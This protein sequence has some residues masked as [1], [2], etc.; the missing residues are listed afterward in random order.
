MPREKVDNSGKG[1]CMYY[2]YSISLM[3]FLL[4]KRNPEFAEQIFTKLELSE[5]QKKQLH[6]L[7]KNPQKLHFSAEQ[8][9]TIIEP[10]L[11]EATRR[12]AA[13]Q[14]KEE[15]LHKPKRS[16]L[17]TA[18][19]YGLLY[20]FR[21]EL[22]KNQ[23]PLAVLFEDQE[24]NLPDYT[25]AE[26]YKVFNI[27]KPDSELHQHMAKHYPTIIDRYFA[28][29]STQAEKIY[30][31]KLALLKRK[32]IE[33]YE[34][35][36]QFIKDLLQEGKLDFPQVINKFVSQWDLFLQ[37]TYEESD[38]TLSKI[39]LAKKPEL[40]YQFLHRL[41][42]KK[43]LS[44]IEAKAQ[45]PQEWEAY[46][47]KIVKEEIFTQEEIQAHILH[48]RLF[49]KEIIQNK[50][51]PFKEV[52][53]D[54]QTAWLALI[55]KLY[56]DQK[57]SIRKD[58]LSVTPF[59]HNAFLSNLVFETASQFFTANNNLNINKY[60]AHLDT[61]TVWGS[62]ETL[63]NLHDY[64][65]GRQEYPNGNDGVD[66]VY[67]NEM[68]LEIYHN[69]VP[70]SGSQLRR[71]DLLLN[72]LGR[73]HWVSLVEP[74]AAR[75]S[76]PTENHAKKTVVF[77]LEDKSKEEDSRLSI[78]LSQANKTTNQS[79]TDPISPTENRMAHLTFCGFN[80]Y[81]EQLE[82]KA[83]LLVKKSVKASEEAFNLCARLA[84][85]RKKF[86]AP[87]ATMSTK[88]FA[89][90][91]QGLIKEAPKCH[92]EKHRGIGIILNG[93]LNALI[94]L[95][96]IALRTGN[97]IYGR[98][99]L[100]DP[101]R[102]NTE[103]IKQVKAIDVSLEALKAIRARDDQKLIGLPPLAVAPESPRFK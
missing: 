62:E 18:I 35:Q 63:I 20:L 1:N 89:E 100:I 23:S 12:M 49:C 17:L 59:Y 38:K 82:E 78:H 87:N 55:E 51:L 64:L 96:N 54:H 61:N 30:Q 57:D 103:S 9:A 58:E 44:F 68:L 75:V 42:P 36:Q 85:E 52:I 76:S 53:K 3:Y 34:V 71:P 101:N 77:K 70:S 19:N 88:E 84:E 66:I 81:L 14:V 31:E 6:A 8:I 93:I 5:L 48:Q 22:E 13:L 15:L 86:I 32:I 47:A 4:N 39:D 46:V 50:T 83:A 56:Q 79:T 41:L 2:A 11:G 90:R 69:G 43:E 65:Q 40:R 21:L 45:Y 16:S 25:E 24:F 74:S 67:D 97:F 28:E 37:K 95:A 92:L 29:W 26:I 33:E 73:F 102:I 91:C 99:E 27:R 72:N 94:C 7:L 98:Y 80:T 60:I 10:I